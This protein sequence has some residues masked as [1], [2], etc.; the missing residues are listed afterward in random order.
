MSPV[1]PEDSILLSLPFGGT[2]LQRIGVSRPE[3]DAI[4]EDFRKIYM[5]ESSESDAKFG[6]LDLLRRR[7]PSPTE[8]P[9]FKDNSEDN[10]QHIELESSVDEQLDEK[11]ESPR[12]INIVFEQIVNKLPQPGSLIV[13][14]EIAR[15]NSLDKYEDD[16]EASSSPPKV[17]QAPGLE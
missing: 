5:E 1:L 14:S 2:V 10:F 8:E 3:V 16:E 9:D 15:H 11:L 6:F 17:L 13:S 4:L 12:K 7:L